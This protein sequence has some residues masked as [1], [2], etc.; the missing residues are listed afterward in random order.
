VVDEEPE[1]LVHG[2]MDALEKGDLAPPSPAAPEV[3]P[4]PATADEATALLA[5][6]RP[7]RSSPDALERLLER[8]ANPNLQNGI[9]SVSP[10]WNVLH[11]A[12]REDLTGMRKLLLDYGATNTQEHD[13]YWE[14]KVS[15]YKHEK[16]WIRQ[17]YEDPR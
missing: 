7:I 2:W 16:A 13:R 10:L 9:G 1:D 12:K 3:L 15:Y 11:W 5:R 6:F 17:M 8:R 14:W 4:D